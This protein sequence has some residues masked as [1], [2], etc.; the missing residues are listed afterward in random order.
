MTF[1]LPLQGAQAPFTLSTNHSLPATQNMFIAEVI[2]H[3]TAT[4][5]DSSMQGKKLL[6]LRPQL[7][8]ENNPTQFRNGQ[9]TI[10]AVDNVGAGEGELVMFSQGSSA[11]QAE[12]LKPLPIDAAV[13]AIVDSV[14]VLGQNIYKCG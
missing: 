8:D 2:G 6:I 9:N 5:K 4:K 3:I 7:V 12:G 13:I 10:I 11:R 1:C 14:N